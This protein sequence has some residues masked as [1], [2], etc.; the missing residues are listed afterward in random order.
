MNQMYTYVSYFVLFCHHSVSLNKK[1]ANTICEFLFFS[2]R[3]FHL[4]SYGLY[5]EIEKIKCRDIFQNRVM[6]LSRNLH[7]IVKLPNGITDNTHVKYLGVLSL[8]IE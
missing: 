5:H 1:K 7:V 4:E 3:L 6:K 8:A 2:T